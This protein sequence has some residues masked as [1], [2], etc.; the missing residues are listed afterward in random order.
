MRR[1]R[2]ATVFFI[3]QTFAHALAGNVTE[4]NSPLPYGCEM[5]VRSEPTAAGREAAQ[6]VFPPVQMQVRT[7]VEPTALRSDGWNYLIYEL[8]LQNFTT[9]PVIVRGIQVLDADQRVTTAVAELK[10]TPVSARLRKVTIGADTGNLR[11]LGV[12]EGAV[13]FLCLAFDAQN[14]IPS[15][16]R[17]RVLLGNTVAEGPAIKT[18]TT[19]LQVL[20]RP[21]V[22]TN[23]TPDNNPS[24]HSHHRMGLWVVDG[25]A[26]ISRRY[27]LDWKKYDS[28]GKTYAGDARDVRSYYAYGQKVLAVADG[29]VIAAR[30]G[31]PDNVPKTEAGFEPARP[32][33]LETIGGNQVV[34]DLGNG[35]FAAYYH[36]Q[37]GSLRVKTGDRVRRGQ[38]LAHVG[39][40]G[41]TRWPHLHFQ[42]TDKADAMASEGIPQLFDSYRSKTGD[43]EWKT[44][45]AEYPMGNVVID[46]GPDKEER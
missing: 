32:V 5:A 45:T 24:L 9:E 28:N 4:M 22:G 1:A 10:E 13:V 33:T 40:S 3:C 31:F 36:L 25:D 23:W 20:G 15:K 43:Q 38:L 42:V 8:H 26:R 2:H 6:S 16:L 39:N 14:P 35:Q 18:N 11:H 27:A 19:Q 12:S 17:H 29:N 44:R 41:D 46:F 30:D 37:P 21:L 34:I 7:P